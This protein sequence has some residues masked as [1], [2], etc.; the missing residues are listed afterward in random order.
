MV[1][2]LPLR[3]VKAGLVITGREICE[4][5][6]KDG[7][8]PVLREKLAS[9]GSSVLSVAFVPDDAGMIAAEIRKCLEAGADLVIASGGMSVDP[10]DVTRH[11]ICAAGAEDV[12]YG[13]P[14]LPGAMLLVSRIGEVPVLGLP[15][16]GMYHA[17]TVLDLILPRLLTGERIGRAELAELG[18]GG[19]CRHCTFCTYPVCGFGKVSAN[20]S[21][22]IF[23]RFSIAYIS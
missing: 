6:I 12:V 14:V 17:I 2:V 3:R 11:G 16:C 18:Y 9:L 7:F 23:F 10:D 15:A 21:G 1:R 22:S 8:E 4:G 19:L 13:T 20:F 5:R